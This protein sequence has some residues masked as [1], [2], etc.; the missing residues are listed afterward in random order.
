[1]A[2]TEL[3][4]RLSLAT[5]VALAAGLGLTV[6]PAAARAQKGGAPKAAAAAPAGR[7]LSLPD[8]IQLALTAYPRIEAATHAEEAAEHEM[9]AAEALKLPRL[10]LQNILKDSDNFKRFTPLGPIGP[11]LSDINNDSASITG[12]VIELP[13][14]VGDRLAILPRIAQ[15]KKDAQQQ[16][17]RKLVQDVILEIL[18]L[19]LDVLVREKEV[20]IESERLKSRE[21]AI[22]QAQEQVKGDPLASPKLLGLELEAAELR[23]RAAGLR[24]GTEAA[25]QKLAALT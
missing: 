15:K 22:R 7:L 4:R 8:A 23:E 21:A 2:P 18:E 1:M 20:K 6:F 3:P 19:Y 16:L 11:I 25:R 10:S 5:A 24:A 17:K 13:V 9:R 14:Y 12:A